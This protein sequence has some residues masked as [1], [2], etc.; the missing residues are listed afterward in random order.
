MIGR[1]AQCRKFL[2]DLAA[3]VGI[4]RQVIEKLFNIDIA[5]GCDQVEIMSCRVLR[6]A[7]R[8]KPVKVPVDVIKQA[9]DAPAGVKAVDAVKRASGEF[10]LER[11][12][13]G[14]RPDQPMTV[15]GPD[16]P[17]IGVKVAK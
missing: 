3:I 4:D 6:F 5:G 2:V 15:P 7:R 14:V 11:A 1:Y 16:V 8:V 9:R 12:P 17:D 10:F 13:V